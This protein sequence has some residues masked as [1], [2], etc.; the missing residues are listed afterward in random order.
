[1]LLSVTAFGVDG[2]K[3]GPGHIDSRVE[4]LLKNFESKLHEMSDEEFKVRWVNQC[5][6]LK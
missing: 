4:L 2:F 5:I 3:Q 6:Y 1:M